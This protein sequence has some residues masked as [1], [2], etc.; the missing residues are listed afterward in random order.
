M[1]ELVLGFQCSL[2]LCCHTFLIC[3]RNQINEDAKMSLAEGATD[4][5]AGGAGRRVAK[6]TGKMIKGKVQELMG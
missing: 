3:Q 4:A 1:A 2:I 6:P 5:H